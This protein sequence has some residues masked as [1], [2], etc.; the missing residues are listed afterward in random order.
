MIAALD[1]RTR[2]LEP[3][4]AGRSVD[5]LHLLLRNHPGRHQEGGTHAAGRPCP[6]LDGNRAP[7]S[8]A[9]RAQTTSAAVTGAAGAGA[10]PA[11]V[12]RG[13]TTT[14]AT[15]SKRLEGT[16]IAAPEPRAEFARR[17]PPGG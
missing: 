13:S 1:S 6:V 16:I 2:P 9:T 4:R 15:R 10:I 5:R 11:T 8:A 14:A 3:A 17:L 12:T 7:S